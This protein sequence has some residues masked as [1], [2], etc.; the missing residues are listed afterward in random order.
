VTNPKVSIIIPTHN[1][2]HLIGE[3]LDSIIAQTY[4]NWE[5][6][7]VDDG[8][9]D[10]TQQV[11]QN[12]ISKDTR[13]QFHKRPA[14]KPKGANACRNY[15]LDNSKGD[16]II[17]L[18]SD[19]VF[20]NT[21]FEKRIA[22][23]KKYD[24]DIIITSMGLFTEVN[25]LLVD[26]KRLVFNA[27]LEKTIDEF[28]I[29]YRLPWN[30]TRPMFKSSLIKN[31]IY[32]DERL[33]RFQDI[34]FNIRLLQTLKPSYL[35]IDYT[36]CYYRSTIDSRKRYS[37][38]SFTDIFFQSF[39]ILYENIFFSL[40]KNQKARLRDGIIL[41]LFIFIK[42]FY[43]KTNDSNQVRQIID[44]LVKELDIN[45]IHKSALFGMY[46]LNKYYYKKMGYVKINILIKKIL[47]FYN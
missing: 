16:F 11:I 23:F 33:L 17:F 34:E 29:G 8:S 25:N 12:Y 1:R 41:K 14:E 35:S 28:I 45:L 6:I 21:C 32:F 22:C 2:A 40:N 43:R 37:T 13:F 10:D 30:I 31:N 7:I 42:R 26:E 47:V 15:G 19:D 3:T 44:L 9:T 24:V 39:Y 4:T 38:K 20:L 18:D 27:N 36:D 46:Y 5:C